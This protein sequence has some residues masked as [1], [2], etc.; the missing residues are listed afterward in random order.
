MFRPK[1]RYYQFIHQQRNMRTQ[2]K[3]FVSH[4]E[5]YSIQFLVISKS[6]LLQNIVLLL[7]GEPQV[8]LLAGAELGRLLVEL[9][10]ALLDLP[11]L[12]LPEGLQW[13]DEVVVGALQHPVPLV[14]DGV[15]EAAELLEA[16]GDHELIVRL[17]GPDAVEPEVDQVA[18]QAPLG[19]G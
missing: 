8:P 16:A 10:L 15:D 12:L 3:Y 4:T 14:L 5:Y 7:G 11:H 9:L 19:L 13:H 1:S 18:G 17:V 6:H 2:C